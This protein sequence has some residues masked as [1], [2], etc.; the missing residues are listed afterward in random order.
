MEPPM[1]SL[2]SA[3][4]EC[5]PDVIIPSAQRLGSLY[6]STAFSRA[7][8]AVG[9]PTDVPIPA[10]AADLLERAFPMQ[11]GFLFTVAVSHAETD[12]LVAHARKIIAAA[13]TRRAA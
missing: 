13:K 12:A 10:E 4:H 6:R 8:E 3:E 7:L 11:R 2:S 1:S 9:I 5:R